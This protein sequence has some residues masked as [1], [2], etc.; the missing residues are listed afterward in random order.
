MKLTHSE[1][2]GKELHCIKDAL[3]N[4]Q[5]GYRHLSELLNEKQPHKVVL[6]LNVRVAKALNHH[7]MSFNKGNRWVIDDI[8]K[9]RMYD[10]PAY[11]TDLTL[12]LQA[13]R[14]FHKLYP[15][16]S[17]V[18]HHQ[19]GLGYTVSITGKKD[20]NIPHFNA[21]SDSYF[22]PTAICEAICKHAEEGK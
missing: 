11:D 14:D 3:R 7:V 2:V 17:V 18:I 21:I 22:L 6:P 15:R 9:E 10:V 8:I 16:L 12:A 4:A 19:S 20:I 13:L 5:D 1:E